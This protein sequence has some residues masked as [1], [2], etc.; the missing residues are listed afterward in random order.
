V[1]VTNKLAGT[2]ASIG[3]THAIYGIIEARFKQLEKHLACYTVAAGSTLESFTEL[4][5]QHPVGV[6]GF[7]LFRQ[8]LSVVGSLLLLTSQSVLSGRILPAL[9]SFIETKNW[10]AECTGFF[11]S[12]TSIT[13]HY[14][15]CAILNLE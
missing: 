12:W 6:L 14:V 5:F 15:E 2:S 13:S 3:D 9:K 8:L 7:L 4:T 10:F 1:A 11:G